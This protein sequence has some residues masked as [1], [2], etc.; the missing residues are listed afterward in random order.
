MPDQRK[1]AN[2]G[3]LA[4]A[5]SV[6]L[7]SSDY[8]TARNLQLGHIVTSS[9]KAQMLLF[10]LCPDKEHRSTPAVGIFLSWWP[11]PIDREL[12]MVGKC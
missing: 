7:S 4:V 8:S 10:A 9:L 11:D 12:P 3:M 6:L 5:N 1:E 2:S